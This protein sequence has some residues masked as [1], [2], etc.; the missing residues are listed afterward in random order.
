MPTAN[1]RSMYLLRCLVAL[2]CFVSFAVDQAEA[3]P[4]TNSTPPPIR[5]AADLIQMMSRATVYVF[6][7]EPRR[8]LGTAFIVAYPCGSQKPGMAFSFLVTAKHVIEKQ[9]KIYVVFPETAADSNKSGRVLCD[10][11]A[12][13]R[14]H[15]FFEHPE[16]DVVAVRF[17]IPAEVKYELIP[18][19]LLATPEIFSSVQIHPTDHVVYPSLLANVADSNFSVVRTGSIA[20]T[21]NQQK[22]EL[23][24]GDRDHPIISKQEIFLI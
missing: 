9:S 15:D 19:E 12:K 18:F 4:P 16:T 3:N 5:T 17:S 23:N 13:K 6:S 14:E 8:P 11:D 10:L 24:L 20:R 7:D 1:V 2:V 21:P 22:I